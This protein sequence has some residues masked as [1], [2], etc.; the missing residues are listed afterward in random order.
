LKSKILTLINLLM[1]TEKW[2]PIKKLGTF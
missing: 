2:I 1:N